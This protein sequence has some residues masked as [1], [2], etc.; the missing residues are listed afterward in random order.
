MEAK[1]SICSG[2]ITEVYTRDSEKWA[3]GG[4]RGGGERTSS[5]VQ[6]SQ[7][8][9]AVFS[10]PPPSLYESCLPHR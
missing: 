9:S 10:V 7:S 4:D 8:L 3:G 6:G 2:N 5:Y 1:S